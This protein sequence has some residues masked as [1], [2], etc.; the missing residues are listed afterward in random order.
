MKRLFFTIL[1]GSLFLA[2]I[3]NAGYNQERR[4]LT[5]AKILQDALKAPKTGI[6][7]KLLHNAKAIAIFPNTR[8]AAFLVGG[9]VGKGILCIK[10]EEGRWSEPVFV[11]MEGLSIGMQLGFKATDLIIIFKTDR[12][13][14]D[15]ESGKITIGVDAGVVA[16]AKGVQDGFKTDEYLAAD[17]AS[18]GKS[19][20]AFLGMSVSGA[21]LH[22]SNND[23]FDYYDELVYVN[24]ILTHDRIKDKPESKKLKQVLDSL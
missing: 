22:I 24:D 13:L 7:K 4:V 5:S 17:S 18:Y 9:R 15:L 19:S 10:N 2:S 14:D 23:N 11:N 12:S 16:V 8:K 6:T 3:L 21:S 20:G 1:L